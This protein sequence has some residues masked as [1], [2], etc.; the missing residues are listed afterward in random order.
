[1]FRFFDFFQQDLLIVIINGLGKLGVRSYE[2]DNLIS[3]RVLAGD[4]RNE[5]EPASEVRRI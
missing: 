5:Q 3:L 2:F 1:M 4:Y